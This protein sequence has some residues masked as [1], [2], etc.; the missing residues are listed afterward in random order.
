[1]ASMA[2]K[3]WIWIAGLAAAVGFGG[4]TKADLRLAD[5]IAEDWGFEPGEPVVVETG[6]GYDIS[7]AEVMRHLGAI[8]GD[9]RPP[10]GAMTPRFGLHPGDSPAAGAPWNFP[11]AG[12]AMEPGPDGRGP[13]FEWPADEAP[14]FGPIPAPDPDAPA[15]P[16]KKTAPSD[17]KFDK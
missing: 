3:H 6:E 5:E 11:W 10:M 16:A 14:E 8:R 12:G 13:V 1:M 17:A 2:P 15:K 4:C 7:Y 9:G